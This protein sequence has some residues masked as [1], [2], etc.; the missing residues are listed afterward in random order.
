MTPQELKADFEELVDYY[1]D[2]LGEVSNFSELMELN[3]YCKDRVVNLGYM[4]FNETWGK[5]YN[6]KATEED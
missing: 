5:G 3:W 6:T 4:A 1:Y 2:K